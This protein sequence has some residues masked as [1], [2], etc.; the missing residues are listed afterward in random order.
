MQFNICVWRLMTIT[1]T[2]NPLEGIYFH[3]Q[4]F[5]MSYYINMLFIP[6]ERLGFSG[7]ML[8]LLLL[9]STL[10]NWVEKRA[11]AVFILS[12][13]ENL[14][15]LFHCASTEC[16]LTCN[17]EQ[18][19]RWQKRRSSFQLWAF[20]YKGASRILAQVQY[21]QPPVGLLAVTF[22]IHHLPPG[23]PDTFNVAY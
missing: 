15:H 10:N 13:C 5:G 19:S 8:I 12:L 21:G 16:K 9:S 18:T 7:Y 22:V 23:G 1:Q 4:L 20:W 14:Q 11:S 6:P 3:L 17:P 2:Q